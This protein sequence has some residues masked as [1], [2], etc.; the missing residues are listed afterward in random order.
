MGGG[1]HESEAMAWYDEGARQGD[2]KALFKLGEAY[3]RGRGVAADPVQALSWYTLAE[4]QGYERAS[5]R[6]ARLGAAL[7]PAATQAAAQQAD[8]WRRD[9]G[10]H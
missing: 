8:L 10:A 2:A 7:D 1:P 6:V 4:E 3:E 5:E 9:H